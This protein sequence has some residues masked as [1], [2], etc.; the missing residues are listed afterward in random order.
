MMAKR[1]VVLTYETVRD[2][3]LKFGEAYAKRMRSRSPRPGDRWH[4]DKVFLRI[5][6]KLQYLWRAVDQDGD[7]LDILVQPRRDKRAAKRFF[8]KLLKG[9]QYVARAFIADK[10]GRYAAAKKE[11]LPSVEHRRNRWLNIR[12][13]NSHEPPRE[14]ERRMRGFNSSGHAQRCLSVFGVIASFFRLGRHLLAA[15]NYQLPR[16][17]AS[18]LHAV[19]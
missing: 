14:R 18:P 9:L 7:M 2:W 10:L 17:H 15:V 19:A 6:G 11:L 16:D 12:A 1:G 5:S 4:L 3:C 8:R 13:E